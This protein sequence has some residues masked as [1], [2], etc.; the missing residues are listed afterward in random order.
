MNT[1]IDSLI[2]EYYNFL[3]GNTAV[4]T[5]TGTEWNVISTPFTGAFND[6]IEIYVKREGENFILSDDGETLYNL[7]L[8]GVSITHS[9]KRK[10]IANRILLTYGIEDVNGE[11]IVEADKKI[12]RKKNII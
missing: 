8:Q 10:E 7:N 4:F 9:P 6:T 11:F 2:D 3:K 12:S 5:E 1:W